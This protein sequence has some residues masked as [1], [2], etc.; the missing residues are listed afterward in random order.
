MEQARK[1]KSAVTALISTACPFALL[2][3]LMLSLSSCQ[4]QDPGRYYRWDDITEEQVGHEY[5][6]VVKKD[7]EVA[8]V[9]YL[10]SP[11]EKKVDCK[12][13][14]REGNESEDAR[15]TLP[16]GTI[17]RLIQVRTS[18]SCLVSPIIV[19]FFKTFGMSCTFKNVKDGKMYFYYP[20]SKP[21]IPQPFTDQEIV[22]T[23]GSRFVDFFINSAEFKQYFAPLRKP[24]IITQSGFE[25]PHY[26]MF[27]KNPGIKDCIS[28]H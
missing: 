27:S 4:M 25:P 7:V 21:I 28:P 23:R 22:E 9:K 5:D 26:Y 15:E 11:E 12:T 24:R 16:K 2:I 19:A 6:F 3:L 17:V 18:R 20:K 1:E 13:R 8:K 10:L 14:L